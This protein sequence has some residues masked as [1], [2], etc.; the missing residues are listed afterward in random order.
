M[1]YGGTTPIQDARIEACVARV[2]KQ[3]H[4]KVSAIKIC[5][6]SILRKGKGK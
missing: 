1:P 4:D 2:M 6:A 5:K 3:G